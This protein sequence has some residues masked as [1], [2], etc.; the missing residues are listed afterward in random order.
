M[1]VGGGLSDGKEIF[2][3][4]VSLPI[5]RR[6]DNRIE[7]DPIVEMHPMGLLH[8]TLARLDLATQTLPK[9]PL[10]YGVKTLA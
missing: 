2:Y 5:L 1:G 4:S 10:G 9:H 3:S 6:K 7:V 8:T